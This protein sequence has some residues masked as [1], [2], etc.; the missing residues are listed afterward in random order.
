MAKI[1]NALALYEKLKRLKMPIDQRLEK[2]VQEERKRLR[3]AKQD[4]RRRKQKQR[5]EAA[6]GFY[7]DGIM[8]AYSAAR[9]MPDNEK[10]RDALKRTLRRFTK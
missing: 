2:Q 10:I 5:R 7:H 1:K 8:A 9:G 6:C 4:E 3:R